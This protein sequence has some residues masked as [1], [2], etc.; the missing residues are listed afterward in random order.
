MGSLNGT[1]LNSR[2]INHPD[3]GSRHWSDPIELTN[4]DILTLGTTS[5]VHVSLPSY[6]LTS[7]H[8]NYGNRFYRQFELSTIS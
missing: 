3:S 2:P 8:F 4:G 1:L 5:S 6:S 7:M